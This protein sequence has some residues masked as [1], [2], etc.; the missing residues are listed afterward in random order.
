M[1]ETFTPSIPS[2]SRRS[3]ASNAAA[4]VDIPVEAQ[5]LYQISQIVSRTQ[6]WKPALDQIS[7]LVRSIFIFDNLALYL[8]EDPEQNFEVMY[9]RAVGRGRSSEADVA[10]G[11]EL[12]SQVLAERRTIIREAPGGSAEDRPG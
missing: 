8:C 7:R 10:W 3:A 4:A 1:A 11:E 12:A 2:S 6:E 9:A 5:Q